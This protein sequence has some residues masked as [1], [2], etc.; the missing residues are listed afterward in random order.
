MKLFRQKFSLI[1]ILLVGIFSSSSLSQ[2]VIKSNFTDKN[3]VA[4]ACANPT[5]TP[6]PKPKPKP[7]P[8]E[9]KVE[10]ESPEEPE[11]AEELVKTSEKSIQTEA[12]V[13]VSLCV[14]EGKVKVTGWDRNE[15][16]VFVNEGNSIGFKVRQKDKSSDK[17]VLLDV[18]NSNSKGEKPCLS[19]EEIEIDVPKTATVEFGGQESETNFDSIYKVRIETNSGNISLNNIENGV[20]AKTY[21]GLITLEKIKG[22]VNVYS[23]SGGIIAYNISPN[24]PSDSFKARTESGVINLKN[25]SHSRLE[26]KSISGIIKY[27]GE[28]INGG[29]Y[30]FGTTSGAIML[31]IPNDSSCKII[32]TYGFG[33]FTSEIPF[34]TLTKDVSSKAQK[35]VVQMGTGEA[36]VFISTFSSVIKINSLKK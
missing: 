16:R 6:K 12:K 9:A 8:P 21:E 18:V 20:E 23:S 30:N 24:E 29:S 10:A 17:P 14:N 26:T 31:T 11:E 2:N 33:S 22:N 27:S 3:S 34:K 35:M 13:N 19:G 28:I 4:E 15:V 36:D 5:P 32:A 7:K 1:F 25:V